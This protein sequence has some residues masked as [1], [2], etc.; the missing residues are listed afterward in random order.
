MS[1]LACSSPVINTAFLFFSM[2]F[3]CLSTAL[4]KPLLSGTPVMGSLVSYLTSLVCG[5]DISLSH[6][7]GMCELLLFLREHIAI[8]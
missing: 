7:F 6:E 1:I 5:V 8:P 4:G 2:R 3:L